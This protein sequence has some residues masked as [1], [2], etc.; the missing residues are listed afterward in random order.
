[1]FKNIVPI[2]KEKHLKTKVKAVNNFDFVKDVHIASV[3]VHEFSRASSVYPIV[4]LEDQAKDQFKPVV[5]TGLEEGENLF[6][7]GNKWDASYIPAIVRRYPFALA[8]TGK[9]SQYTICIDE[10][11]EFVNEE[12]GQSLFNEQ[13]EAGEVIEKVKQYLTELQQMEQFTIEFSA[14]MSKNNMFTPLNMK[15]RV[16]SEV[17]NISGAYVINE[18]RFN[19][20]SDEKFIEMRSK[21]YIPVIYSHLSSLAQIERLVAFKDEKN[22]AQK[23]ENLD[24]IENKTALED[25]TAEV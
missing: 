7:E 16:G 2:N 15:V 1:M 22:K 20:L 11:S 17:K 23:S 8:Q 4:F 21:K 3:M 10:E 14:Y 6:V 9:D 18:E 12:E 24:V 25:E 19:A 13:G 5:L